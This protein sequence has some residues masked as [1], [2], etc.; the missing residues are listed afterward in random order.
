METPHENRPDLYENDYPCII[1]K[2]ENKSDILWGVTFRI[3][4][5]FLETVFSFKLPPSESLPLVQG[6]LS[7]NYFTGNRSATRA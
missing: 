6:T 4:M 7:S 1:H 2:Q 5:V 3:L